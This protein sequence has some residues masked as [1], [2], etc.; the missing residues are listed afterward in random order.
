M[1]EGS[2][3]NERCHLQGSSPWTVC[4]ISHISQSALNMEIL[5]SSPT[6]NKHSVIIFR[7]HH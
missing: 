4:G 7:I 3:D 2:S 6:H 5:N 1:A